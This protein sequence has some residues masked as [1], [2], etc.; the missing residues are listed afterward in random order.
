MP[1]HLF[2]RRGPNLILVSAETKINANSD[3]QFLEQTQSQYH[4]KPAWI[5]ASGR[6]RTW[7]LKDPYGTQM[8]VITTKGAALKLARLLNRVAEAE[9][10]F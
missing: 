8:A 4:V 9:L 2:R 6:T 10:L 5:D 1:E 3:E 7:A